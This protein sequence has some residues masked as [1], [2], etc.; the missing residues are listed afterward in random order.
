MRLICLVFQN[1]LKHFTVDKD[2][3]RVAVVTYSTTVSVD[4]DD[5]EPRS[6]ADEETMCTVSA[7][8]NNILTRKLPH[9]YTATY[10]ALV[11][12]YKSLLNSRPTAKKAVLVITD[13]KSNIGPPPLKAALDILSLR[14]QQ[15]WDAQMLGPQVRQDLVVEY[16]FLTAQVLTRRWIRN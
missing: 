12:V 4:F 5:L 14:W 2:N 13:G 9:G 3:T 15:T 8:L 6:S 11:S 7:R 1:I 10:D 16:A